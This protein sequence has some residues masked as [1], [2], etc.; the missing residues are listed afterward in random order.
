MRIIAGKYRSRI[1]VD[2]DSEG[3][4]PTSDRVKESLFGILSPRIYGSRGL[5][6]FC[7]SGNLG[8]EAL[9]RGAKE[10]VFNDSAKASVEILKKNLR[11]LKIEGQEILNCDYMSALERVSGTFDIIF[12]D[13]PYKEAFESSALRKIAQRGLLSDGGVVVYEKDRL[14][15]ENIEGL[16]RF[17]ARGYGKTYLSFF[18]KI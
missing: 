5:D 17:D 4:R 9:S 6:L 16:E 8:I 18:R 2:F 3:L 1:L 7:G 15:E 10:V 12:L 14:I 13:P 11:A